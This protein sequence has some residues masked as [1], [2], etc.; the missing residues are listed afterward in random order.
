MKSPLTIK[1]KIT[2]LQVLKVNLRRKIE[3]GVLTNQWELVFTLPGLGTMS[4]EDDFNVEVYDTGLPKEERKWFETTVG[5][6]KK[7]L[8]V[9][10]YVKKKLPTS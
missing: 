6:L 2:G 5:E 4:L 9:G 1:V 8:L 7:D 3:K 10:K